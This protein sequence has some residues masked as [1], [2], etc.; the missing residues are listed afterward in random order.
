MSVHELELSEEQE[1]VYKQ[2]AKFKKF[3]IYQ[4]EVIFPKSG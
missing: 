4:L 3:D 1:F 2:L